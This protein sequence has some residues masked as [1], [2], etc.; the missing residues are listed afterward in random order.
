MLYLSG[1]A[2][3]SKE[4]PLE[5]ATQGEFFLTPLDPF[6]TVADLFQN[7]SLF[8]HPKSA[9]IDV[10]KPRQGSDAHFPLG[11]R[12]LTQQDSQQRRLAQPIAAGHSNASTTG[13]I[14]TEIGEETTS[15]ELH[16]HALYLHDPVTQ[17]RRRWDDQFH[18]GFGGRRTRT[19]GGGKS[20]QTRLTLARLGLRTT[21]HPLNLASQ[22]HLTLVFGD[23]LGG[24][25]LGPLEQVFRVVAIVAFKLAVAQFDNGRSHGVEKMPVMGDHQ[26]AAR[27][28]RQ[29]LRDP[30]HRFGVQMVGRLIEH[31]E[32]RPGDQGPSQ[33]HATTF[34]TGQ[35]ADPPIIR[36]ATQLI[37]GR[38]NPRIDR[39]A[40]E[41]L[42]TLFQMVMSTRVTRE[43]L[44][45]MNEGKDMP[46][47]ISR[48]LEDCDVGIQ[49]KGLG[50]ITGDQVPAP[51][52]HTVIDLGFTGQDTHEGRFASTV[53]T[54][55]PDAI[56][57]R[58][59]Q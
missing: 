38:A 4:E 30:F 51:G 40:L 31:Q 25:L 57:R 6:G 19:V 15:P 26:Q 52:D 39:P 34:S 29:E 44:K 16:A 14:Q 42:D 21:T 23:L 13:E 58:Q 45:L 18:L 12:H 22:E 1:D 56:P 47:P 46:C 28:A 20:I 3:I 48:G 32:V 2:I 41:L 5:V 50:Q 59:G 35:F 37:E 9:L 10:V 27:I 17:R 24:Q 53:A 7:G 36:R 55:K 54:H 43:I 8:V 49:F 33:S 11:R